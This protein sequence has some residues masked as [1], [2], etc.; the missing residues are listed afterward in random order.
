LWV[1]GRGRVLL[2]LDGRQALA[3]DAESLGASVE[4]PISRGAH[5][6]EV[7]YERVGPGPRL[8]LGWSAPGAWLLSAR[9]EPIPP[10]RLGPPLASAWWLLTDFLALLGGVLLAL[11]S[12]RAP[13][14]LPRP[15]PSA[16]PASGLEI[17]V[18][19]C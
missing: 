2:R 13:W 16:R 14:D 3:A 18:A 5:A 1:G 8:R 17:A 4:L 9:D 6:L 15:L 10:R 7:E 11:L 12:L 19:S